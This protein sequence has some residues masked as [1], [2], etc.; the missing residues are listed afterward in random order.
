MLSWVFC[1]VKFVQLGHVQRIGLGLGPGDADLFQCLV[2]G[3]VLVFYE[4][5]RNDRATAALAC[6]TM[7]QHS[8]STGKS[9]VDEGQGLRE[10]LVNAVL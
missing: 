7:H 4:V 9:I 5:R 6:P 8:T 2:T 1:V 10:I 3:Q